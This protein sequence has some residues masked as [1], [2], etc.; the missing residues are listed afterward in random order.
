M[1]SLPPI[2]LRLR[3]W[4]LIDRVALAFLL[5]FIA[6]RAPC[7]HVRAAEKSEDKLRT[8]KEQDVYEAVLQ[9]LMQDWVSRLD[10]DEVQ[11]KNPADKESAAHYNFKIFFIEICE[12]D[13]TDAFMNRFTN[14]PRTL[15]KL[16]DSNILR[17]SVSMPVV[18][19]K[20][21]EPGI[22]FRAGSLS[23]RGDRH[24]RVK[25]GYHCDGLCGA[26]YKFDVRYERGRWVV[27]KQRMEWIS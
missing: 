13:P 26:G 11:A 16:S 22:V 24:A 23:W 18:E 7:Q 20:T 2:T 1:L 12:K 6:A 5:A 19:K 17:T 9:R 21:G 15:K 10:K 25:G 3:G 14:I 4:K 8:A 27:K